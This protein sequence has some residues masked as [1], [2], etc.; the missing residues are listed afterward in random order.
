M[1]WVVFGLDPAL[2]G[3]AEGEVPDGARQAQNSAGNAAYKGPCPPGGSSHRYRF[4]VYAL[5]ESLGLSDGAG[6]GE[7]LDA[8]RDHAAARGRLEARFER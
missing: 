3:L 7:A 6:V 8:I 4:T 1:H 2:S 5:N